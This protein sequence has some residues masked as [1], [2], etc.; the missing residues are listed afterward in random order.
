MAWL[1]VLAAQFP[2]FTHDVQSEHGDDDIADEYD[3]R[4]DEK[5]TVVV[6]WDYITQRVAYFD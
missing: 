1:C 3:W 5:R 6:S 4:W 2:L